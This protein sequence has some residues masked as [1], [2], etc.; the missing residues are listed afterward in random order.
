MTFAAGEVAPGLIDGEIVLRPGEVNGCNEPIP[1]VTFPFQRGLACKRM[2][3]SC[4]YPA[5]SGYKTLLFEFANGFFRLSHATKGAVKN[6]DGAQ[7]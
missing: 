3:L 7:S 1:F 2:L 5:A 4:F 6:S